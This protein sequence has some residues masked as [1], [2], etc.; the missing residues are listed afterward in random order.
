LYCAIR[1]VTAEHE[2]QIERQHAE[3]TFRIGVVE[4]GCAVYEYQP[5]SQGKQGRIEWVGAIRT[6]TGYEPDELSAGGFEGWMRLIHPDDVAHVRQILE[7]C[8]ETQQPHTVD[9]RLQ[10][11]DGTYVPVLDRG[12]HMQETGFDSPRMIGALIDLTAIRHQETA[13][14]RSEERYRIIA[15]QVGAVILE[16]ETAT[17]RVRAFGP[18][19]Q[20]FGYTAEQLE[21]RP[22]TRDDT[23]IHPEDRAHYFAA[24]DKAEQELSSYYVEHRRRHRGGHYIYIGAR[25]I[26]LPGPDGRAERE[27]I[28]V[29]DITDRKRAEL[30]LQESEERF[31]FAIE[32]SNQVIYEYALNAELRSESRRFAGAIEAMLGFTSQEMHELYTEKNYTLIHPDDLI[33]VRNLLRTAM[34]GNGTFTAEHRIRHKDGHYVHV[35]TRG[36]L[37][38]N[39][40]GQI[41]GILGIMLDISAAKSAETDRRQYTAQLR[42]LAEIAHRVSTFL[43]L[44]ELLKYLTNSMR[45]LLGTNA[46]AAIVADQT[47]SPEDVIAVSY[48]EHYGPQH[49]MP[50]SLASKE[51]HDEVRNSNTPRRYTALQMADDPILAQLTQRD[52]LR[53]PL[54]GWLGAP[55]IGRDGVNLGLLEV[56][57]KKEG[58]F[59]ESDLQVLNQLAGLASV[60]IENIRLYA[61]L[62]ERVT[63][64]T[65]ELEISNRELEA[66]S[67]SVS[68]DLRAPLRAIAGF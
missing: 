61:T 67:Y 7:R 64:R 24:V 63:A 55:L 52:E 3:N 13:L 29:T 28:A 9:Y 1:D 8:I 44:H 56:S 57:D 17:G 11:K 62:E 37:R 42:S 33:I 31:R 58:D 40:R 65:R 34:N 50:Q 21:S 4:A 60:A 53:H 35:E 46:A 49:S 14:R 16:R 39:D 12:R 26:V 36:A 59:S 18:V 54:R 66:F 27:I 25:G 10:R 15:S 45:E 68:H 41:A 47:L 6:L 30:A 22:L 2:S 20:I 32:Q 19:E 43:S 48:A 51:L 38:Y 23:M 5:H